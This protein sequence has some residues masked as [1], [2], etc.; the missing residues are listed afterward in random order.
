MDL[1]A[2]ES[3]RPAVSVD[4]QRLRHR[5]MY[6]RPR[7]WYSPSISAPADVTSVLQGAIDLSSWESP[8]ASEVNP[9]LL[10]WL[11]SPIV[12]EATSAAAK[13]RALEGLPG[14][15]PPAHG[16]GELPRVPQQVGG[17]VQKYFYV[18]RPLLAVK[19][20]EAGTAWRRWRSGSCRPHHHG[21]GL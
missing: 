15:A 5:F 11:N 6:V 16:A 3:N 1:Y 19:W 20:I 13:L 7:D 2:C 8:R 18:L 10:E 14:A 17:L 12:Y 9:P 4:G 21:P